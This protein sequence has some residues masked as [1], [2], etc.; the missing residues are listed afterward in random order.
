[1][2]IS[3]STCCWLDVEVKELREMTLSILADCTNPRLVTITFNLVV[4]V[5]VM[6]MLIDTV[7]ITVMIMEMVMVMVKDAVSWSYI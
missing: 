2:K 5:T 6:V 7:M 4:M 3:K 1:M